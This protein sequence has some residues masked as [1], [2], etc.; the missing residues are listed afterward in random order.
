[1]VEKLGGKVVYDQDR[2]PHRVIAVDLSSTKVADS[3]MAALSKSL[4]RLPELKSLDLSKTGLT[5]VGFSHLYGLTGLSLLKVA[6]TKIT[7]IGLAELRKKLQARISLRPQ[8][9]KFFPRRRD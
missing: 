3:D 8:D 9:A 4:K 5:D 1:M 7:G 6:R 2:P